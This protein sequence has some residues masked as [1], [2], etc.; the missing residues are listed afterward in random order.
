MSGQR[1]S[2]EARQTILK[3]LAITMPAKSP[4][5]K[6]PLQ[7]GCAI[8]ERSEQLQRDA[9]LEARVMQIL[10]VAGS[11]TLRSSP[12]SLVRSSSPSES[13]REVSSEASSG[14]GQTRRCMGWDSRQPVWTSKFNTAG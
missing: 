4:D 11:V 14:V 2:I 10:L 12:K 3:T 9:Y 7:T 6:G 13:D 5:L 1:L 8:V